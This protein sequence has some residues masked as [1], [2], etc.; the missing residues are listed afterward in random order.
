MTPIIVRVPVICYVLWP[1]DLGPLITAWFPS[2]LTLSEGR[3]SHVLRNGPGWAWKLHI[4][5]LKKREN[6]KEKYYMDESPKDEILKMLP[7]RQV[8]TACI[9]WFINSG[10]DQ[11][12]SGTPAKNSFNVFESNVCNNYMYESYERY[13][14][15][16]RLSFTKVKCIKTRDFTASKCIFLII[17]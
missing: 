6:A 11:F 17:G 14:L 7:H 15:I 4:L 2:L 16:V 13:T 10:L 8:N 12:R 3:K 9:L 1:W 5:K